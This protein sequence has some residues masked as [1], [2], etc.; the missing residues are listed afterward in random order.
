MP[1]TETRTVLAGLSRAQLREWVS[2]TLGEPAYRGAQL[3]QWIY[4]KAAADF[5]VMTDLPAA[6]AHA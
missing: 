3:A 6:C 1:T 4:E 2:T 5:S